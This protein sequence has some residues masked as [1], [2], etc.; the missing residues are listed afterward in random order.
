MTLAAAGEAD[1]NGSFLHD[2]LEGL[3]ASPKRIPP[4]YFYDETGS[5]LFEEICRT[6]EYYPTRVEAALLA[7]IAPEVAE[8]TPESAALVEFGSGASEKTRSLL[9][10]AP[11]LAAYAP[12][13]I[14]G[15]ALAQA[16]NRIA[17][18][19]PALQ[20][21]P[22]V[23]DFTLLERL[24]PALSGRPKVGFF[25]GSTIGNFAPPE[26]AAL[27]RR[28]KH[29]L[30]QGAH[31]LI[32][33]DLAKSEAVL[34][35]AY[36]DAAGVTAA[37]NLN[38]LARINRE[39]GGDFDLSAFSH[40]AFWNAREGRVEMHLVSARDQTVRVDG[41]AFAFRRDETIH[42]ENSYK[43]DPEG[44]ARLAQSAGWRVE[45]MWTSPPP[46]FAAFLLREP[47]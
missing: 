39:L 21:I 36:N 12:I 6:P 25:P 46:E 4:K 35:A 17:A 27:L 23:D 29:L 3:A 44:F 15:A 16:A 24:P 14:S 7:R 34:N 20:V 37:F 19:Y 43:Y 13:D 1:P 2:V 10:A 42:T 45:Q 9:D 32:G 41:A 38:L 47:R 18:A 33:V 11:Q 28:A 22:V 26:A 8:A 31:F 5:R 40:R 30:G